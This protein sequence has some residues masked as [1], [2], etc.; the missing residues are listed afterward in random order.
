MLTHLVSDDPQ[1]GKF[2]RPEPVGHGRRH[3]ARRGQPATAQHGSLDLARFETPQ[4]LRGPLRGTSGQDR[5]ASL[6][7]LGKPLRVIVGDLTSCPSLPDHGVDVGQT[8]GVGLLDG[9]GEIVGEHGTPMGA[10]T[11]LRRSRKRSC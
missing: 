7:G 5:P 3:D 8:G 10:R 6:Y 4:A 11:R 2:G 1:D 9:A